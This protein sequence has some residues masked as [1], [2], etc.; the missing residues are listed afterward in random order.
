[1]RK[2]LMI[3]ALVATPFV[4]AKK[5]T[6]IDPLQVT[7][8]TVYPAHVNTVDRAVR[9][10]IEPTGY[11]LLTEHPAPDTVTKVLDKP[12]ADKA[13]LNRVMPV[14]DA[15][16]L[17]IGEKNTIILDKKNHLITFSKGH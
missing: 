11:T 15:I 2:F 12:I 3:A 10:L 1:M 16:Q 5:P 8:R 9:W 13:K 7:V 4:S 17:L 6:N 14:I